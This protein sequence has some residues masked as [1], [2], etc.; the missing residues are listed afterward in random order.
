MFVILK[1]YVYLKGRERWRWGERG[2]SVHGIT[3]PRLAAVRASRPQLGSWPSVWLSAMADAAPGAPVYLSPGRASAG[4]WIRSGETDTAQK[5]LVGDAHSR[6]SG[7]VGFPQTSGTTHEDA[8]EKQR[9]W[10]PDASRRL[11]LE[12]GGSLAVPGLGSRGQRSMPSHGGP[13]FLE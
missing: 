6:R 1:H 13:R 7:F 10:A 5:Q 11:R 8:F 12:Q 4:S 9:L 2:R 3:L